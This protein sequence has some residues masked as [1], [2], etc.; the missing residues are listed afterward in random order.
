[1]E[2]T[3]DSEKNEDEVKKICGYT[4]DELSQMPFGQLW[5]VLINCEEF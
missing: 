1:M 2:Q 3:M 4:M 5:Q